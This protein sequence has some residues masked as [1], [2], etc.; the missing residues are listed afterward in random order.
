MFT[1]GDRIVVRSTD[2]NAG[3]VTNVGRFLRYKR[4]LAGEVVAIEYEWH[5]LTAYVRLDAADIAPFTRSA[6][7]DAAG[8]IA[9]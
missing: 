4:N 9:A 3:F 2:P 6:F 7:D 1:P 8:R 5:G